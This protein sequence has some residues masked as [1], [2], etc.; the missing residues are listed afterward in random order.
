MKLMNFTKYSVVAAMALVLAGCAMIQPAAPVVSAGDQLKRQQAMAVSDHLIVPGQRIGPIYLGM[1]LD[2][3]AATLG[4]PDYAVN[5]YG[6]QGDWKYVSLNLSIFFYTASAAP[7]VTSLQ[8]VAWND[9]GKTLGQS[10]WADCEPITTVFQTATGIGLGATSYNVREAY[11]AY[12]YQD[13]DGYGMNYKQLGIY[14]ALQ[15]D[16]R[17]TTIIVSPR[18]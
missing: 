10:T 7:S 4:Q 15:S 1:G 17:V 9:T 13:M 8:T 5:L 16:R 11:S 3:V 2:Q 18:Q 12:G 6:G 14:F